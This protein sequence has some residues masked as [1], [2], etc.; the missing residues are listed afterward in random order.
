MDLKVPNVDFKLP[1]VELSRGD[2]S[3]V[4]LKRPDLDLSD[5]PALKDAGKAVGEL[6]GSV[7]DRLG[8]VGK[9]IQN[10]RRPEPERVPDATATGLALLGGLGLGMGMMYF[11]DPAQG[12]RRRAL[13]LDKVRGAGRVAGGQMAGTAR[14]VRERGPSALARVRS[15]PQRVS[16]VVSSLSGRG[17]QEASDVGGYASHGAAEVSGLGDAAMQGNNG[18]GAAGSE[19][20]GQGWG[21][22]GS[23]GSTGG[24]DV[25]AGTAAG[26]PGAWDQPGSSTTDVGAGTP[27][28][29]STGFVDQPGTSGYVDPTTGYATTAGSDAQ[30]EVGETGSYGA[31]LAGAGRVEGTPA[32]TGTT[33]WVEGGT[34]PLSDRGES[35]AESATSERSP[36]G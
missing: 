14:V 36:W 1:K 24:T 30:G 35:G 5:L 26:T 10:W 13:L 11:F 8:Q 16:G 34:T 31:G 21:G 7:A 25:T 17:K 2:R 18:S 9:G 15:A 4:D 27:L 32:G 20:Y 19:L 33:G 6:R 29:E 22:T 23:A 12:G 3:L 28:G